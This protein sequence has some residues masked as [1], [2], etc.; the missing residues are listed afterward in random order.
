MASFGKRRQV[1]IAA[2]FAHM[3]S[4]IVAQLHTCILFSWRTKG[5]WTG[6]RGDDWQ[7]E[8]MGYIAPR[9]PRITLEA[10]LQARQLSFL[11]LRGGAVMRTIK[12]RALLYGSCPLYRDM[13]LCYQCR[14]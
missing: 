10:V 13:A 3:N 11:L 1:W 4:C 9:S 6:T 8:R 14:V 7:K 2:A 5:A 12:S